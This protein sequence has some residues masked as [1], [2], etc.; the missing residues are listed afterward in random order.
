MKKPTSINLQVY[1]AK[2][3]NG[4]VVPSFL[5]DNKKKALV[6]MT[7][8]YSSDI[9]KLRWTPITEKW[10]DIMSS[11][12][13]WD[14]DYKLLLQVPEFQKLHDQEIKPLKTKFARNE[15]CWLLVNPSGS[16]WVIRIFKIWK[17][18]G[19]KLE[20]PK[21]NLEHNPLP[22]DEEKI[23]KEYI[24]HWKIVDVESGHVTDTNEDAINKFSKLE[25]W[26]FLKKYVMATR[27]ALQIDGTAKGGFVQFGKKVWKI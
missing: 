11:G 27:K 10:E 22:L 8:H 14:K 2:D 19:W 9:N 18:L 1:S 20:A 26:E 15:Q 13:T 4:N 25:E 6:S 17:F 16:T 23:K 21:C 24:A 5:Y 7:S 12:G 3:C